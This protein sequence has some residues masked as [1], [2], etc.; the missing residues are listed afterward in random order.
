MSIFRLLDRNSRRAFQQAHA[1][2]MAHAQSVYDKHADKDTVFSEWDGPGYHA[3]SAA[4]PWREA[5]DEYFY[6]MRDLGQDGWRG[7][8]KFNRELKTK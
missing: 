8:K 5:W 3:Y 2:A 1:A 6:M 4:S 7:Y